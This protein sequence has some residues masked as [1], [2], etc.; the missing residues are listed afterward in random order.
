LR[1]SRRRL[2]LGRRDDGRAAGVQRKNKVVYLVAQRL[3]DLSA[4][5]AGVA[6]RSP[7]RRGF[8]ALSV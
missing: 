3:T 7:T 1:R 8:R 6:E 5:L 2:I 4:E